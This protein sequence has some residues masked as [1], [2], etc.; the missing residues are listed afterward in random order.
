MS[1]HYA[2]LILLGGGHAQIA[3]LRDFAMRPLEGVRITLISRDVRTPYSGMLP[4]AIEGYY[5]LDEASIDLARLA[6]WAGAGF[7]HD[8]AVGIDADA[9]QVHLAQHPPLTYDRL[10]INIGS[11]PDLSAIPGAERFAIGV[12]PVDIFAGALDGLAPEKHKA[13]QIAII[14]GG[15][16]GAEL[17]LALRA[18]FAS[19]KPSQNHSGNRLTLFEASNRLT[20]QLTA[21]ASQLVA[22]ACRVRDIAVT[23]NAEVGAIGEGVIH[24][25]THNAIHGGKAGGTKSKPVSHSLA[26][27][28]VIIATGASPPDWLDASQLA[29]DKGGFIV[30]DATL[31][32][33]SHADVFAAGDIASQAHYPL[34]KSGVYAVRAGKWL[35]TNLRRS[36]LGLPLVAWRPQKRTLALIGVG[37]SKAIVV[38]GNLA[39][40]AT[41]LAWRLKETIDRR[42]IARY[43]DLPS[44]PAPPM[45]EIQQQQQASTSQSSDPIFKPML[46]FGCGAKSGWGVLTESITT[47]FTAAEAIRPDLNIPPTPT[48]ALGED[49]AVRPPLAKTADKAG[50][51]EWV[52]SVDMVSPVIS[53][54]LLFGRIAALHAMSDVFAAYAT[55]RHAQAMLVVRAS[56]RPIQQDDITHMLTG[57]LLALAEIDTPAQLIGGHTTTAEASL[58]GLAVSGTRRK[59]PAIRPPQAGDKLILTKPLGIGMV[60]AGYHQQHKDLTAYDVEEATKVMLV[61]NGGAMAAIEALGLGRFAMTDVTGFGLLRHCQSLLS[62]NPSP[63]TAELSLAGIPF[64]SRAKH[65]AAAGVVA[66]LAHDNWDG[67]EASIKGLAKAN[68]TPLIALLNDPQTS[69]GLLIAVPATQA[70]AIVSALNTSTDSQAAIIGRLRARKPRQPAITIRRSDP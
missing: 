46:C 9:R 55:P 13:K 5:H 41:R 6:H 44:M 15:V 65:L 25:V 50:A 67:V 24:Y 62:R 8:Y 52:D 14:G 53:D 49:V 7:I 23:L 10:A 54:P 4:G 45:T 64:L 17:A 18:R 21:K 57:V 51:I 34:P 59:T 58:L 32:S 29:T 20:P 66:S 27:D 61:S 70:E 28:A 30:V 33:T 40:P 47:A 31:A 19:Q 3:V 11:T 12:K 38:R 69:G 43:S 39:L 1:P 56:T 22:E 36:L 60:L 16:A 2:H 35:A 63:L 42:F 37:G 48:Q 68:T 26:T